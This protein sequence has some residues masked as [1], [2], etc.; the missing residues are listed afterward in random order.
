MSRTTEFNST[1]KYVN[2][3]FIYSQLFILFMMHGS[4][5]IQPT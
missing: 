5:M 1:N 3:T 4:S 2:I